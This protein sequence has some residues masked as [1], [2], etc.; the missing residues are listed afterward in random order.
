M[1]LNEYQ[2]YAYSYSL[3]S[4]RNIN[5]LLL[6]LSGEV[7]ELHSVFAKHVRDGGSIG[8][9]N[10]KKELGDVLWFVAALAEFHGFTLDDVAQTNLDKLN[11][12]KQR[13]TIGG[14][15]DER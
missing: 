11:S 3:D 10:V 6:G 8:W 14:S 7:G 12:R 15:G 5:Y 1:T 2:R 13:G 4:A 9:N